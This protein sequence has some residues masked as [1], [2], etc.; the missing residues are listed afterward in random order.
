MACCVHT[1]ERYRRPRLAA[2]CPNTINPHLPLLTHTH[3]HTHPQVIVRTWVGG[4][5]LDCVPHKD[6][7]MVVIKPVSGFLRGVVFFL[8]GGA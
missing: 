5:Q 2:D 4:L 7:E 1:N 3:T 6:T 8:G